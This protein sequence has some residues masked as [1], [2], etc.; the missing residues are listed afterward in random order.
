[1]RIW[2]LNP[3]FRMSAVSGVYAAAFVAM[4]E[5]M[6]ITFESETRVEQ[7]RARRGLAAIV[8]SCAWELIYDGDDGSCPQTGNCGNA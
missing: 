4:A 6:E 5:Q 2:S 1:M 7:Y 3:L 8:G